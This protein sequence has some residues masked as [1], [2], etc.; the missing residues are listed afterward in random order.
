M[1]K[2]YTVAHV[3]ERL[4]DALDEAEQGVNVIIE[5]RGTRFRLSVASDA[6]RRSRRR[7]PKIEVLDPAV[8]DGQWSWTWT[9]RSLSLRA[10]KRR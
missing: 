9:P 2:R 8:A 3:R 1:N 7:K 6:P 5:R 10:R 4:S